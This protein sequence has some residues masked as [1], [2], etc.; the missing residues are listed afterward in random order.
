[1]S[2]HPTGRMALTLG[3]S[4]KKAKLWNLLTGKM[5]VLFKLDQGLDFCLKLPSIKGTKLHLGRDFRDLPATLKWSPSGNLWAVQWTTQLDVYS[6]SGSTKLPVKSIAL[7]SRLTCFCWV[8]EDVV[9]LGSE[10]GAIT[11]VSL[12]AEAIARQEL[13]GSRIKDLSYLDGA[14]CAATSS[15]RVVLFR[16]DKPLEIDL[17]DRLTCLATVDN[18]EHGEPKVKPSKK[19]KAKKVITRTEAE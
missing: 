15:G 12:A 14:A 4:S 11:W 17:D 19:K 8:D 10:E 6:A 7:E 2:L 5:A 1:M 18:A 3:E 16:G 9:V 13:L